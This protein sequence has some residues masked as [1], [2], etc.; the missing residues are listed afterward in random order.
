[1]GGHQSWRSGPIDL[2]SAREFDRASRSQEWLESRR[3]RCGDHEV[4]RRG[5]VLCRLLGS[6]LFVEGIEQFLFAANPAAQF[7]QQQTELF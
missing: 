2:P 7:G 3:S 4:F 5:S 6:D 1:M